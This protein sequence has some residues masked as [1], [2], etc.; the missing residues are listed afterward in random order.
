MAGVIPNVG[1]NRCVE[2]IVNKVSQ[3]DLKLKLYTNNVTPGEATILSDLTESTGTGYAAITFTGA[4][5]TVTGGVASYAE[6]T[7]TYTGAEAT[8]YGYYI[9]NNAGD[10]LIAA[11]LF[12]DGPYVIPA[13]GGTINVTASLT[14]S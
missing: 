1:E 5:W 8:V 10:E 11:E 12:S 6:Q 14:G 4:S 9:T 7:F 2:F 3:G 13:G